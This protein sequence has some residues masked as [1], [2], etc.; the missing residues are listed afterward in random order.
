[1][2]AQLI[3][4]DA[5]WH[6]WGFTDGPKEIGNTLDAALFA[7][8]DSGSDCSGGGNRSDASCSSPIEWNR[9]MVFQDITMRLLGARLLRV[10]SHDVRV[11]GELQSNMVLLPPH[12]GKDYHIYCS[13][14]NKGANELLEEFNANGLA[15]L[16]HT[17]LLEQL[18]RC[19]GMLLYLHRSTWTADSCEAL[20]EECLRALKE[21][22]P[23]FLAHET[24]RAD[25]RNGAMFAEAN[26]IT[27]EELM[28]KTPPQL[29]NEGVYSQI[30]SALKGGEWRAAS[31]QMLAKSF[32]AQSRS[33]QRE[34]WRMP[35]VANYLLGYCCSCGWFERTQR[36]RVVAC[37]LPREVASMEERMTRSLMASSNSPS[38]ARV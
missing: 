17:R 27:F 15:G 1:M 11:R 12:A 22:V 25:S 23:I 4:A 35:A 14:H 37:P 3:A 9:V 8:R 6:D 13:P 20:E 18:P 7:T 31:L 19:E 26:G 5:R 2:R 29:I 32:A 16:K 21:K 38:S 33:R 30:A 10:G 34:Y 24:P 28:H 36:V